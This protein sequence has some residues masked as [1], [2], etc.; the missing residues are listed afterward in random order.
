VAVNANVTRAAPTDVMLAVVE[1]GISTKVTRGENGGTTIDNEA[2]VR[3]LIRVG[4]GSL[5]T[6]V[7]I[8]LDKSWNPARLGVVAFLQDRKTMAIRGAAVAHF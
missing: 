6:N 3:R 4:T 7:A 8:P 1:N 2:I 5:D